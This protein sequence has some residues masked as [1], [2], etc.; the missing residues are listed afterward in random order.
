MSLWQ[1]SSKLLCIWYITLYYI[2]IGTSTSVC[3]CIA[4]KHVL[5]I[6]QGSTILW[7]MTQCAKYWEIK[8]A[9]QMT[10]D[11]YASQVTYEIVVLYEL[12][13]RMNISRWW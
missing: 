2:P 10:N 12:N 3:K 8:T 1:P 5:H 7:R 9:T 13:W 11:F 6:A 4:R